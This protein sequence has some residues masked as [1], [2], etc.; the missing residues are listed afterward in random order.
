MM[1]L[2]TYL[3]GAFQLVAMFIPSDAERPSFFKR[4]RLH[5]GEGAHDEEWLQL[6]LFESP[7]LVI[8]DRMDA[9]AGNF[10]PIVRELP[11]TREGGVVFL[12]I[13]GVSRTGRLVLIE[14]KLWRN[15]QARREVIA[16]TLE[17]AALTRGLTYGD[18]T[19]KVRQST[20]NHLSLNPIYDLAKQRWPKLDEST[21][22]DAVSRS[23]DLGDFY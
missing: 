8:L 10:V 9:D 11:L 5:A 6:L 15:P 1:S 22:V 21:F 3:Q 14:C 13:L 16:Q 17:Y 18:L 12:D 19:A 20:G 7:E 4:S 23:L 2:Q